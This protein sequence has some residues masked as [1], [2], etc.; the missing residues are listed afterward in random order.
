MLTIPQPVQKRAAD[1]SSA[2]GDGRQH[3]NE[4]D[5]SRLARY[6]SEPGKR[7]CQNRSRQADQP[8]DKSVDA[9]PRRTLT[10]THRS[11]QHLLDHT[12]QRRRNA[13]ELLHV[14]LLF[15]ALGPAPASSSLPCGH[16]R[17][18][19]NVA[20]RRRLARDSASA[21]GAG[22]HDGSQTSTTDHPPLLSEKT[23]RSQALPGVV[24]DIKLS[25]LQWHSRK[26]ESGLSGIM[27]YYL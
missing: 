19:A 13:P 16:R 23:C 10:L 27:C 3:H 8:G 25:R 26:K 1:C 5:G 7:R 24:C 11:R 12:R 6:A 15:G 21:H 2:Y 20:R 4:D 22:K 18:A 9:S 17:E 14:A